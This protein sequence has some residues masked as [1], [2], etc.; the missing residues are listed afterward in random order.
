MKKM[1]KLSLVAAVAVAGLTTTS[2]ASSLEDAV[3]NTSLSGYV[4][5]RLNTDEVTTAGTVTDVGGEPAVEGKAAFNFKTKVNDNVTSHV[6]LL[7][8]YSEG[9]QGDSISSDGTLKVNQAN[10]IVKAGKAT[11]IAG[12]QTTQSPFAANNG[13]TRSNGVT[14]LIPAGPVTIAAAYYN[15]TITSTFVDNEIT[16]LGA[17]GKFGPANVEAWYAILNQGEK[18]TTA[19]AF[20]ASAKV[21]PATVAAHHATKENDNVAG[22]AGE[23]ENTQL[24]ASMKAGPANVLVAYA[25]TGKNSGDVTFDG[26]TDSK[27]IYALETISTKTADVDAFVVGASMPV[28]PVK[29]GLTY[30]TGDAGTA[31]I[32]EMKLSVGYK[33][34]KNFNVSAWYSDA[35][36][37]T[38]DTTKTR[39]EVKYTF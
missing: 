31:D 20:M 35:E 11:V 1:I 27:L 10:F 3:K 12:L 13:D 16:A 14:A 33:M 38:T 19:M 4:R 5:Y 36:V 6:K 21:G 18:D 2:A 32:S 17:I 8:L 39:V 9:D 22:V 29:A 26:D 25:T 30:L 34:S 15:N 24:S 7:G 37:G 23:S 28:G